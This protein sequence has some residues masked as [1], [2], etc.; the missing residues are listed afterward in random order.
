MGERTFEIEHRPGEEWVLRFRPRR[1]RLL[2]KE[3]MRRICG[4][5]KGVLLT[6]RSL[7]ERAIERVE[8]REKAKGGTEIEI[9]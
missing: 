1:L 5:Q 8:E 3:T 6:L 4:G 9:G 2:R 7:I